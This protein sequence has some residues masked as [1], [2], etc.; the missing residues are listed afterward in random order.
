[1]LPAVRKRII[2]VGF[3][4]CLS[5]PYWGPQLHRTPGTILGGQTTSPVAAAASPLSAYPGTS[6]ST[7]DGRC[8]LGL[9][10]LVVEGNVVHQKVAAHMI[11]GLGFTVQVVANGQEAV[12][13]LRTVPHD[14]VFVDCAMAFMNRFQA[15]A[16][17]RY[18]GADGGMHQS[19]EPD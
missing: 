8:P 17:I 2:D 4:A 1:V 14:V 9:H 16:A 11:R 7:R 5:K 12:E 19:P 13:M 6:A 10:L 18:W 3:A 15:T